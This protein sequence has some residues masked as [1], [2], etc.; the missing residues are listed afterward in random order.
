VTKEHVNAVAEE[1]GSTAHSSREAES[2]IGALRDRESLET[3]ARYMA[4]R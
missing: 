4:R 2:L 3:M 1:A